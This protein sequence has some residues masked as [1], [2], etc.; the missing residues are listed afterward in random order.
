MKTTREA[1]N[2]PPYQLP[3]QG[4]YERINMSYI[5]IALLVQLKL[6]LKHLH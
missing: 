2:E 4:T 1:K 6:P 5:I 3:E